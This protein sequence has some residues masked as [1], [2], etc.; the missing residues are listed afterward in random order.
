MSQNTV[1]DD[2]GDTPA[3]GA[4]AEQRW[5]ALPP[6]EVA[7]RLGV[8]PSQG[9]SAGKAAELLEKNGPNALPA[10]E[11]A[12]GWKLFLAQYRAYMQI[13]LLAAA[14]ASF[15]IGEFTTGVV[16]VL[17][18]ALNALGGL[19]QQGKA[20]SAMNALQ[21][22]LKTS[23]RVRRDGTEGKIDAD[24]GVVGD[25]VLLAAGDDVCADGRLVEATS[26]QIDES[27]LTG[28]SVPASKSAEII[29]D[30][31][32]VLGD[33]SNMAFMNTPVTHGGGVMIVTGTGADTAVGT[34]SGMLKS[35]PKVKTPLTKQLD[36]L[37]L[38]IAAAAGLTI[39][40]MFTLGI[41]RGQSA[42]VIFT[43]AIALALAAVPMAM[44]TVLQVIL[45]SGA[46][47]L[48]AHGAVVKNLDSVETLGSTSAIN[49]DK[50]G[51]LTMNQVTVVEV[52][53]PTDRYAITGMG[54]GLDG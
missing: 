33:Q 21:S 41:S 30:Q 32:P 1:T 20:E 29:T 36:T 22:M 14:I 51:T 25:V 48:A 6:E 9:L 34:I 12:P 27:A 31:N 50:T 2:H 24:Q 15:L 19:R 23:A 49:S 3:D 16:V 18:T 13:I 8:D 43:T 52:I 5:Y 39:A 44:P 35:A 17:I 11:P 45:S 54:Y 28:E 38:W 40:I 10:E 37:T 7:R 46:R 42:Q 47:E 26:L 53:D 4:P